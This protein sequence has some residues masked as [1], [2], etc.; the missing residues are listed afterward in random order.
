MAKITAD[1]ILNG[2]VNIVN[3]KDKKKA[4]KA[5][6]ILV[7]N[8]CISTN[9]VTMEEAHRLTKQAATGNVTIELFSTLGKLSTDLKVALEPAKKDA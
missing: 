7:V 8:G 2:L 6:Y 4:K 1:D 9:M 5:K 3:K